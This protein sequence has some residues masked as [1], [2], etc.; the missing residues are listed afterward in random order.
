MTTII[1]TIPTA[2]EDARQTFIVETLITAFSDMMADEPL[3]WKS[4][5]RKMCATPFAF[6]RG[7]AILFLQDLMDLDDDSFL[8]D[9]TSAVWIHGDLHAENFGTYMNSAGFLVFDVN[10]FDEAYIGPFTWDLRRLT[11]SL[12]LIG[13]AKALSDEEIDTVVR[14][15]V[16]SYV[17]QI[18]KFSESESTSGFALT[19][20]NTSGK[21]RDLLLEARLKSRV[22]FL[23]KFSKIEGHD[24]SLRT[25]SGA[26]HL[27]DDRRDLIDASFHSYVESIPRR[28]LMPSL[29]YTVKDIVKV[30]GAGIGSAGYKMYSILMEGANQAL[31]N[32]IL[33]SM[34]VGQTPASSRVA[35]NEKA[36]GHFLNNAHRTVLSQRALQAYTD[37]W[38]GHTTV[39]NTGMLVS[40]LSPYCLDLDWRDIDKP[41]HI[42]EVASSLG[43]ATA[44]I[45]CVSDID[46]DPNVVPFST[47]KAIYNVV[48]G[49]EDEFIDFISEFGMRYGNVVRDD[50][51]L[52]VDAFR[53]HLFPGL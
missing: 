44:K 21:V 10:D 52:F 18:A 40:E 28:K 6:Y 43:R 1:T 53:N 4:K 3:A 14:S 23:D 48:A 19:L 46:A 45:H 5:F 32:D 11:A 12:A 22:A 37:P 29:S 38:L 20:N 24:R 17:E 2:E 51:R 16:R 36:E 26:I 41:A 33:I 7:S 31:E 25:N 35:K 15:C 8:D 42:V 39:D 9:K 50:H 27:A 13:Y 49:K 47:D 30:I 34:K